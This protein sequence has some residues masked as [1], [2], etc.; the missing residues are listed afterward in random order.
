[1]VVRIRLG[2][3]KIFLLVAERYFAVVVDGS[4]GVVFSF[5][6]RLPPCLTLSYCKLE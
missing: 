3:C 5:V 2:C 4:V 1:M 6:R